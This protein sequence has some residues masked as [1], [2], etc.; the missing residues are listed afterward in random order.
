MVHLNH[1]HN[2]SAMEDGIASAVASA[3]YF[4]SPSGLVSIE[5]QAGFGYDHRAVVDTLGAQQHSLGMNVSLLDA[6]PSMSAIEQYP[7]TP[8]H[9]SLQIFGLLPGIVSNSHAPF[10]AD[11]PHPATIDFISYSS[12]DRNVHVPSGPPEANHGSNYNSFMGAHFLSPPV[13]AGSTSVLPEHRPTINGTNSAPPTAWPRISNVRGHPT[14]SDRGFFVSN[15]TTNHTP[16]PRIEDPTSATHPFPDNFPSASSPGVYSGTQSASSTFL[17]YPRG[18]FS[19]ST[20]IPQE[21]TYP[22]PRRASSKSPVPPPVPPTCRSLL[23]SAGPSEMPFARPVP[24][25]EWTEQEKA[26]RTLR[27]VRTRSEDVFAEYEPCADRTGGRWVCQCGSTFVRDSDWE[28]HAMHSLSHS[29]GGGYD[30]SICDISFTRS[31]AMFRHRRKKHGD[32]MPGGKGAE[33]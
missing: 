21:P 3:G 4:P 18:R 31:D 2:R 22:T 6:S 12:F 20:P 33:R 32:T 8:N 23:S 5:P 14:R 30:C 1:L 7:R 13:A 16:S 9:L 28:R 27:S 10:T 15:D 17:P 29:E 26:G 11:P 19:T 24:P 25:K